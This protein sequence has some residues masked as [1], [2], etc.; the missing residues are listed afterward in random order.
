MA[1][2][3]YLEWSLAKSTRLNEPLFFTYEPTNHLPRSFIISF[4]TLKKRSCKSDLTHHQEEAPSGL[5]LH[6]GPGVLDGSPGH[7]RGD[8]GKLG[9]GSILVLVLQVSLFRAPVVS[10]ADITKSNMACILKHLLLVRA[11]CFCQDLVIL[12][13]KHF[14]ARMQHVQAW[15]CHSYCLG[16]KLHYSI[17]PI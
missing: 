7:P 6:H 15:L 12:C 4:N 9:D 16:F 8:H 10:R 3:N 14:E 5:Q 2:Y 13:R 1:A 11:L 17:R